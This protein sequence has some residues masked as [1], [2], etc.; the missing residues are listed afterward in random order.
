MGSFLRHSSIGWVNKASPGPWH[1]HP[2][3]EIPRYSPGDLS[4]LTPKCELGALQ[5]QPQARCYL[6]PKLCQSRGAEGNGHSQRGSALLGA[7]MGNPSTGMQGLGFW[8]FLKIPAHH[9]PELENTRAL[10]VWSNNNIPQG[11][12]LPLEP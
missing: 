5:P 3:P 4:V 9:C 6:C 1:T 7:G 2:A 8:N 11:L 10:S 12:W